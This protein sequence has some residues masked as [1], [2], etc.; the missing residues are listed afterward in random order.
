MLHARHTWG[1]LIQAPP[2]WY[3]RKPGIGVEQWLAQGLK[4]RQSQSQE[5]NTRGF[6]T[7]SFFIPDGSYSQRSSKFQ[8]E[9]EPQ[10][11]NHRF[12]CLNSLYDIP[13]E[14]V[15]HLPFKWLWWER[16]MTFKGRALHFQK[17]LVVGRFLILNP[18]IVFTCKCYHW[19]Q[20]CNL[21]HL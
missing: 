17:S 15:T 5:K 11:S 6:L 16:V 4:A 8:N 9:K 10:R 1:H 21:E 18:N 7:V 14:M 12:W 20:F 3:T 13:K 19:F 2:F